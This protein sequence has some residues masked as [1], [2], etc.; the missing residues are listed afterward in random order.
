MFNEIS[1]Q[2]EN[3]CWPKRW[4]M[5]AVGSLALAGVFSVILVIARTPQL[6]EVMPA[7]RG[8]F[9]VSLV[10]HVDLSVL[11][12]FLA[13]T[14][15]LWSMLRHQLSIVSMPYFDAASWWCMLLGMA[16]I[17][18]SPLTHEWETIKSN[19][20]P[21]IT[22]LV[23]F[24]G[25]ALVFCSVLIAI[26]QTLYAKIPH[27]ECS[28]VWRGVYWGVPI[29]SIALCAF[30]AS[31]VLLPSGISGIGFYEHVFWAGGHILQFTYMQSMLVA[32]ILI[33]ACLGLRLPARALLRFVFI[34][35]S[36]AVFF[37]F[38]PYLMH[39]VSDQ[40]HMDFFTEQMRGAGGLSGIVLGIAIIWLWLK[41]KG[42]DAAQPAIR[43]CLRM[44]LLLFF[45]GGVFG[46]VINGPNVR[47]PA[48]YHGSIVA[49]TLAL[50]GLA[51][52]ML[53]RLGYA[54]VSRW[55]MAKVQPYLYGFGQLLHISGLA[56]SGGYGVLRKAV[57]DTG[58]G[59]WQ[60]KAALGVMGGGGVLAILGGLFFVIVMFKGFKQK[61]Q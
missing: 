50:M 20:I 10:V 23:F 7:L 54:N 57:G 11:V 61:S 45:V 9:S 60:V 2:M 58:E 14:L 28:A 4:L 25:L 35:G 3:A 36:A 15:F 39:S 31:Y 59:G 30:I 5:L 21:V 6:I 18:L 1:K 26:I 41:H 37:S 42:S 29:T 24:F 8:L 33:A 19:Y 47:I 12:W 48:H 17:A 27:G 56:W 43:G 46:A 32:W 40:E 16:A 44:S 51:Y 49:V 38:I 22:N 13:M 52:A 34:I 53:P 55:K